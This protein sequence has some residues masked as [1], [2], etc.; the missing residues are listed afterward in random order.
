VLLLFDDVVVVELY[1]GMEACLQLQML[2]AGA[3]F[4]FNYLNY[5]FHFIFEQFQY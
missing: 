4:I 1:L 2:L 3:V 5:H